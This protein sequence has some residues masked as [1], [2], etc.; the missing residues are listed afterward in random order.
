[1][2]LCYVENY[3]HLITASKYTTRQAVSEL[4]ECKRPHTKLKCLDYKVY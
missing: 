3:L 1:M 4:M 2:S